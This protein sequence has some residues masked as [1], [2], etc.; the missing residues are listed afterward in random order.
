MQKALA[1]EWHAL[2]PSPSTTIKVL[3][4]IEDAIEYVRNL[5]P[6]LDEEKEFKA[7]KEVEVEALITGSVHLV[8]A[9]LGVLEGV[10]A[11]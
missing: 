9:A 7:N 10:D 8:G 1:E 5:A 6:A 3:P 4:G 2:D 11:L